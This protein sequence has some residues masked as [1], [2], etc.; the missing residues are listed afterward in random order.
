MR[1]LQSWS[2]IHGNFD[3]GGLPE[4]GLQWCFVAAAAVR[5]LQHVSGHHVEPFAFTQLFKVAW[6]YT[7]CAASLT[8]CAG[9]GVAHFAVAGL[10]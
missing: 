3:S 9:I 10:L 2:P 8:W 5:G 6:V 4:K 1:G 7:T